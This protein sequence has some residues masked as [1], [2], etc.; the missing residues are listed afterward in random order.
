MTT[1]IQVLNVREFFNNYAEFPPYG[2][3]SNY[4]CDFT[5]KYIE[6]LVQ[7][8]VLPDSILDHVKAFNVKPETESGAP[9][10]AKPQSTEPGQADLESQFGRELLELAKKYKMILSCCGRMGDRYFGAVGIGSKTDAEYFDAALDVARLYQHGRE[11]ILENFEQIAQSRT[12][13]K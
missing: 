3:V 2:V 10:E 1:P 8:K 5:Y 13:R 7:S 6:Y 12:R 11:N 4:V 9:A